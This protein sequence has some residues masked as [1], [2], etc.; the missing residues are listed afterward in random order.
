MKP[1][2]FVT[3]HVPAY[4]V[5]ALAALH[6]REE[7]ELALFGG[8]PLHGGPQ[9][10]GELPFPHRHVRPRQLARWPRAGDTALWSAR[11]AGASRRWPPGR[12]PARG[13]CAD[14]VGLAV[15]ASP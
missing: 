3:G 15:G 4:R 5:G 8:A 7:I 13:L 9:F 14:P 6:E 12:A 2:L 10:P 1:V 11:R